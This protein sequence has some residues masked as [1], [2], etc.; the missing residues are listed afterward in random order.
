[1]R[2]INLGE[3]EELVLLIVAVLNNKA[4]GV[5]VMQEIDRQTG[6]EVNISAIHS[7]LRRLEEKGY[8]SSDWGKSSSQRGGRRK[9]LYTVTQAGF[10]ALIALKETREKL[11]TQIPQISLS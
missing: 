7:C 11:W 4:Y 5:A 9:R 6:R 1:M 3:L 10:K 8:L 2:R